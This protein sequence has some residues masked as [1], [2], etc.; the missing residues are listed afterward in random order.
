MLVQVRGVEHLRDNPSLM[1]ITP[2]VEVNNDEDG[3]QPEF[4]LVT[5]QYRK[6]KRFGIVTSP[7]SDEVS[8]AV[9]PR[10]DEGAVSVLGDS[11]AGAWWYSKP[12]QAETYLDI[13]LS[14]I[15]AEQDLS[16]VRDQN[17]PGH[18][19][20]LRAGTQWDCQR[21]FRRPPAYLAHRIPG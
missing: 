17:W 8:S 2:S 18:A 21:V 1:S 20:H 10:N 6:A 15:P 14:T 13:P 16:G 19:I 9:V 7:V 5:G 11:A 12:N 4:S 3:Q